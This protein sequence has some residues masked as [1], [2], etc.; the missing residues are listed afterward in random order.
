MRMIIDF[1]SPKDRR[2]RLASATLLKITSK[3]LFYIVISSFFAMPFIWAVFS[4]LKTPQEIYEFPPSLFPRV[5]QW[6]NYVAIWSF[7]PLARFISNTA[8]VTILSS[9]SGICTSTLV[10]YGFSRFRFPLQAPLFLLVLS[11]LML[12]PHVTLIPTFILFKDL[13]WLDTYLP[14]IVPSFFGGG[15]F[16]IFLMRQ[17]F[18]T[19]P[20]DLDEAAQIDGAGYFTI[21]VQILTPLLTPALA[22][23]AVFAFLSH[24]NDFLH[25][26]IYLSTTERFTISIGLQYLQTS[27]FLQL[28]VSP[29]TDHYLLAAAIVSTIP[30]LVIFILAQKQL[31]EG[32]T[33]T[34][35]TG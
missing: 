28:G 29:I 22:A 23:L 1:A 34:G 24:W 32:I 10:A 15:A 27:G 35:L 20:R 18:L 30:S 2:P 12:P 11:T 16:S 17:F 4:S 3:Y 6:E 5:F 8:I 33:V 19:I 26:L 21:L 13:G 7:V 9:V 31:I 14:L 25:P